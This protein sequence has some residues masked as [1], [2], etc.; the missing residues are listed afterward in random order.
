MAVFKLTKES[1][2][3]LELDDNGK[4]VN[5]KYLTPEL[6]TISEQFFKILFSFGRYSYIPYTTDK[7]L[8]YSDF[9]RFYMMLFSKEYDSQTKGTHKHIDQLFSRLNDNDYIN[10]LTGKSVVKRLVVSFLKEQ[11]FV[12]LAS[13]KGDTIEND[14]VKS[15]ATSGI[16]FNDT[17]KDWNLSFGSSTLLFQR[18]NNEIDKSFKIKTF[19]KERKMC[20][21]PIG[22]EEEPN[23][24]ITTPRNKAIYNVLY[25]KQTIYGSWFNSNDF[26]KKVSEQYKREISDDSKLDKMN[27]TIFVWK[28]K[29]ILPKEIKDIIFEKINPQILKNPDKRYYVIRK[30]DE[31]KQGKYIIPQIWLNEVPPN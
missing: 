13:K 19:V 10:F 24:I 3:N 27:K 7:P 28:E 2:G 31:E 12:L 6:R 18:F 20:I 5:I 1:I 25:E 8:E 4:V 29:E 11:R 9:Q 17:D 15:V 26:V 23:P 30:V 21:I 22:L 14:I 16:N